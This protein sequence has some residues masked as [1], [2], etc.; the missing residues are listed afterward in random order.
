MTLEDQKIIEDLQPMIQVIHD[1]NPV[2]FDTI[3]GK[4]SLVLTTLDQD[5][6]V[7]SVLE[8]LDETMYQ[9]KVSYEQEV[10]I[11][12]DFDALEIEV[13]EPVYLEPKEEEVEHEDLLD[14]L[15]E[16]FGYTDD[17]FDD[18]DQEVEE[19]NDSDE[20]EELADLF[21][22]LNEIGFDEEDNDDNNNEEDE[23]QEQELSWLEQR[24]LERQQLKDEYE[25][26]RLQYYQDAHEQEQAENS[27]A[28]D[29]Q[30]EFE[31]DFSDAFEA[32]EDDDDEDSDE[33]TDYYQEEIGDYEVPETD[34]DIP[35]DLDIYE[36]SVWYN[37]SDQGFS[38]DYDF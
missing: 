23:K 2:R 34:D 6:R 33:P 14:G 30:E 29:D 26:E 13:Q 28:E 20:Q 19:K 24:H 10:I 16:A 27:Y 11:E 25:R 17:D 8:Y 36:D 3:L 7:F 12:L 37:V 4:L 32:L 38:F 35:A 9:M 22:D 1:D 21:D 18:Q 15:N 5:T 31:L